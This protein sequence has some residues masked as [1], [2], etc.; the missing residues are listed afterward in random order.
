M[1][2]EEI[3]AQIDAGI[4]SG[5]AALNQAN[6]L[7]ITTL[8]FGLAIVVLIALV[9]ALVVV[10][11]V[12]ILWARNQKASNDTSREAVNTAT[13]LR[14]EAS[15]LRSSQ[16]AVLEN[17]TIRSKA[18]TALA[19]G[20]EA[21]AVA[22]ERITVAVTTMS[23]SMDT[24]SGGQLVM[25]AT[26]MTIKEKINESLRYMSRLELAVDEF[27]AGLSEQGYDIWKL[28]ENEVRPTKKTQEDVKEIADREQVVAS[29]PAA[30]P[31]VPAIAPPEPGDE[32][33]VIV[34]GTLPTVATGS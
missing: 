17:D 27:V 1:T 20:V 18:Q 29:A 30:I 28:A 26:A 24:V 14:I 33:K 23:K 2:P 12:V 6:E 10:L 9:L 8:M 4:A 5:M 25:N 11:V 19:Q 32:I 22:V 16:S 34:S 13:D 7:K 21:I 15:A 3:Q 31:A